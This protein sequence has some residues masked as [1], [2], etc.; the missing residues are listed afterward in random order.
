MYF[1]KQNAQTMTN[2]SIK[3]L[4]I[5]SGLPEVAISKHFKESL[6][7]CNTEVELE[8]LIE[9]RKKLVEDVREKFRE[10]YD[11]LAGNDRPTDEELAAFSD[12]WY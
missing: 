1:D 2:E 8:A 6:L 11:V 4:L 3:A 12:S 5:E 9:R 7:M 10:R